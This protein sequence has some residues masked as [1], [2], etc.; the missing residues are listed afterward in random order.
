MCLFCMKYC[1]NTFGLSAFLFSL[2]LVRHPVNFLDAAH[3]EMVR[4]RQVGVFT[5]FYRQKLW[6]NWSHF[7]FFSVKKIGSCQHSKLQ[8]FWSPSG[9]D[10]ILANEISFYQ[11]GNL[12]SA[13]HFQQ[14]ITYLSYWGICVVWKMHDF[15]FQL[16]EQAK[17][18][19]ED[20]MAERIKV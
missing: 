3:N 8:I 19:S 4:E 5:K 18:L 7:A 20:I 10:I 16:V 2:A 6:N 17:R 13:H 11:F 14:V 15:L 1:I 9:G 12:S